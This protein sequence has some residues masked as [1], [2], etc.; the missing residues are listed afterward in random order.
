MDLDI[1]QSFCS[2][3]KFLPWAFTFTKEFLPWN[4]TKKNYRKMTMNGHFP[5][6]S[7]KTVSL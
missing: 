7:F 4:F 3:Q 2:S 5:I 6:I 1:T